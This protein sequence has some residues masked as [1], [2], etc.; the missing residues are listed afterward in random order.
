MTTFIDIPRMRLQFLKDL[1]FEK[2]LQTKNDDTQV[3]IILDKEQVKIVGPAETIPK[4]SVAVYQAVAN[5][6][7]INLE[8][9]QIAITMLRGRQGQAFM[10]DQ[11]SANNLQAALSFDVENK[12][13]VVVVMGLNTDVLKKLP[14]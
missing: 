13:N 11:F 4:V 5:M 8:M 1:E 2:E 3:S 14:I 10:K 7:E 12:A 9:S 6:K